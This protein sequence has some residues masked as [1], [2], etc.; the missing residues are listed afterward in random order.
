ML[1]LLLPAHAAVLTF[2]HV[3]DGNFSE[4]VPFNYNAPEEKKY[5]DVS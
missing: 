2:D 1:I 5:N 3:I 4:T